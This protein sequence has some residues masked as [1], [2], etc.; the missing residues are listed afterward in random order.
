MNSFRRPRGE[1]GGWG[2]HPGLEAWVW[3]SAQSAESFFPGEMP[4]DSLFGGGSPPPPGPALGWVDGVIPLPGGSLKKPAE[5]HL[6][7]RRL[8]RRWYRC[9][10]D[11]RVFLPAPHQFV[12]ASFSWRVAS[13]KLKYAWAAVRNKFANQL[14]D[15]R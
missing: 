11:W 2:V 4:S 3:V 13:G 1:G 6:W 5:V 9:G 15:S 14:L 7:G 10:G 8:L 12:A